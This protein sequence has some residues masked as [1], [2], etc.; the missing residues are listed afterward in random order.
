[1]NS[2]Q[3]YISNVTKYLLILTFAIFPRD[4]LPVPF[5]AELGQPRAPVF[6]GVEGA[7]PLD[8]NINA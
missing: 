3:L 7:L 1:M 5:P 6:P 8:A 2:Y 4:D